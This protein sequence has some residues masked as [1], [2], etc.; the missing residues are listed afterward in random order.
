MLLHRFGE[1]GLLFIRTSCHT[2]FCSSTFMF[3]TTLVERSGKNSLRFIVGVACTPRQRQAWLVRHSLKLSEIQCDQMTRL[4]FQFWPF[5]T[6]KI[7]PLAKTFFAKVGSK[8]CQK[9]NKPSKIAFYNFAD[10]A[11]FRQIWSHCPRSTFASFE[12]Q[13][14]WKQ[15]L[16]NLIYIYYCA[17]Q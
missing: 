7:H 17:L 16:P 5:T 13:I 1:N 8:F 11:K 2:V 4:C 14:G 12:R 6:V 9:L 3:R 15:R 10:V